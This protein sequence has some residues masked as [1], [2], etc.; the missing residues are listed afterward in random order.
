MPKPDSLARAEVLSP[1]PTP[2]DL[3]KL[4]AAKVAEALG[5]PA[6][7]PDADADSDA[8][9]R[10]FFE[11]REGAVAI[12]RT[13]RVTEQRKWAAH[14]AE[15]GCLHCHRAD[16]MHLSLGLCTNC[17][18]KIGNRLRRILSQS[19]SKRAAKVIP[20][21]DAQKLAQDALAPSIK[22]LAPK[23]TRKELSDGKK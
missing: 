20:L 18:Q 11:S 17:Y 2:S 1:A 3:E 21:V 7:R 8:L 23:R 9:F 10:P 12:K 6:P 5:H 14:F 13:Q 16:V 15:Y 19:E 4:V 22:N